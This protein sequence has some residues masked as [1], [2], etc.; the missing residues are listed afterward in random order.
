MLKRNFDP[1]KPY[2]AVLYLRMS[3]PGQNPRSPDQQEAEIRRV[4]RNL[5]YPWQILKSYRDD[6]IK[7]ALI[8]R[9]AGLQQMLREVKTGT[10]PADL[11]LVD[12]SE[13]FGRADEL[14]DIRRQLRRKCGVLILSAHN[15][16]CDPT[17]PPGQGIGV[18]RGHALDG[19]E[20]ASRRIRSFARSAT[21]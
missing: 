5:R 16:F 14:R 9:R 17:T 7:G 10:M 18:V 13:R 4:L 8:R 11:I 12:T 1:H 19:R 20:T 21:L 6:A 2:K 3:D 15:Q